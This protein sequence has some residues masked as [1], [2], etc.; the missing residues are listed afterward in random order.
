MTQ[1]KRLKKERLKCM[2]GIAPKKTTAVQSRN[3]MKNQSFS[4]LN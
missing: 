3:F 4:V 1:K 2:A